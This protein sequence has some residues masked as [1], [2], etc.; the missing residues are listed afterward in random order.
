[1][2]ELRRQ[3]ADWPPTELALSMIEEDRVVIGDC[4]HFLVEYGG[5]TQKCRVSGIALMNTE[6]VRKRYAVAAM[7][8]VVTLIAKHRI[9][10]APASEDP[11]VAGTAAVK[12]SFSSWMVSGASSARST[13]R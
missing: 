5:K 12:S 3:R 6:C 10:P 7:E 9:E 8:L 11:V 13:R 1:L 4:V 2:L